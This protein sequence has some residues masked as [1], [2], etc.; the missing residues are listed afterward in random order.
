MCK[1]NA[2]LQEILRILLYFDVFSY[3][4]T[5]GELFRYAGVNDAR[6]QEEL[7][8]QMNELVKKGYIGCRSGYFFVAGKD[9]A[10]ERRIKG[11]Q[12]ASRRL[13][14]ARRYSRLI[15]AFPFVRGVFL[16]GSLS[17]GYMDADDDIDYFIVTQPGRL[18]LVRSL[19]VLFKKIFLKNSYRNFCINYFVDTHHLRIPQQNRFTATE[20]AFLMP[21]Y[22][23]QLHTDILDHNRWI[24]K[25]YPSFAQ[26]GA[27]AHERTPGI[28]HL[29]EALLNNRLGD[30]L[31]RRLF[32]ASK[33][34]IQK[35]F[36]WME[37]RRFESAFSIQ[38]HE[39]R[40]LPSE[41]HSR[42]LKRYNWKLRIFERKT[43]MSLAGS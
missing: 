5:K 17:K 26:N 11:N 36:S 20:I 16:S 34:I 41:Q 21:A 18:W 28:K 33:R 25:Y 39:L 8:R 22:N 10:V 38:P 2:M 19:L 23:R 43:A 14:T 27:S 32:D 37:A 4:L 12:Y 29:L 3:P 40:F 7:A 15:A 24:R 35:K 13:R 9:A 1:S 42:I 30:A 6:T 31:E